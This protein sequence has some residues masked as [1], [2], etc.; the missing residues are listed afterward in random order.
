MAWSPVETEARRAY[1]RLVALLASRSGDLAE[2]ED[3]LADAL[4]AALERWPA[5][6]IPANPQGWLVTVAQR[7]SI[8]RARRRARA[9]LALAELVRMQ[10]EAETAMNEDAAYPDQ[11]LGLLLACAH[12]AIDAGARTP[13]MLQAVLGLS[14]ERMASAFL[15]SAAAMTKRLVRAKAKL[16]GAGVRFETPEPEALADRLEPVLDAVYAAFTLSRG[17]EGDDSLQHEA[18][19]LGRLLAEL[20]PGEPEAAGLL[21]LMLLVSARPSPIHGGRYVPVSGQDPA[22]WNGAL[23][24]EAERCLRQAG[25]L[26]RPGRF[27][28]EAAIQAVHADR[29]RRPVTNW[30]AILDL[31]EGLVSMA[32]TIGSHVSRAAAL[33]QSGQPLDAIQ[34]LDALDPDWVKAHQPYWAT[35]AFALAAAGEHTEAAD[36][37]TRAAGL[38]EHPAIRTWLLSQR[39]LHAN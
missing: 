16:A 20:A 33:A 2:A 7:R 25:R 29:R 19:W 39:A 1:G 23:M 38:A 9:D 5:T 17:G 11:R 14:A 36:A 18:L 15:V 24:T 32:P 12:P 34:A 8:D 3:A 21:A 35:R 31:Y 4:L 30:T 27:Q 10:E 13:L 22:C 6:G 37:Y 26:G 28:L